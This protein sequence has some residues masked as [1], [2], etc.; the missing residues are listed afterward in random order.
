VFTDAY[1]RKIIASLRIAESAAREFAA[2]TGKPAVAVGGDV[3]RIG[4]GP[5]AA[6]VQA[7]HLDAYMEIYVKDL[8]GPTGDDIPRKVAIGDHICAVERISLEGNSPAWRAGSPIAEI[9]APEGYEFSGGETS[10]MIH[11]ATD[12]GLLFREALTKI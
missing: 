7:A 10:L 6:R 8:R 5:N 12:I 1:R 3:V 9:F 2:R 4:E 11:N